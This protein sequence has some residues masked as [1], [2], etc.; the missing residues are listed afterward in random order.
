M[1]STEHDFT[2]DS[3]Q[4]QFLD[5]H[6]ASVN[7]EKTPWLIFVGH[8]PMYIDSTYTEGPAGDQPVASL[9]RKHVEPL[10]KVALQCY[11][12]LLVQNVMYFRNMPLTW[13]CGA[14]IILIREL[15]LFIM[16]LVQRMVSLMLL[17]GW[18]GLT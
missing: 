11:A 17:L 6:L 10:L 3:E 1:M 16:R 14:I 9:L 7:R 12:D 18:V 13:L 2:T 8:R 5:N 15:A 4:L